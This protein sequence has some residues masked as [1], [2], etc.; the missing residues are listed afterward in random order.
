MY[1][2]KIKYDFREIMHKNTFI[3][4]LVISD[5]KIFSGV[6]ETIRIGFDSV[7]TKVCKINK[8]IATIITAIFNKFFYS[9]DYITY[10][11]LIYKIT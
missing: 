2:M 3:L 8:S 7:I 10:F 5:I 1:L 6:Q 9:T 4:L 11:I